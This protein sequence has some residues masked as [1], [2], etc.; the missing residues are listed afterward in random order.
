M[1]ISWLSLFWLFFFYSFIGWCIEVCSAAVQHRKFVNRG[2]VAGPLC[3]IYGFGAMLFEIFLPELTEYPFFLFLGGFVLSSL[4]EYSTGMFFEKVY[5]KKLWDYSRFRYNVGGY[6]CLPFSL[7][8]GALS[9][10]T[11]MFADPLLCGLFDRIPHLLSVILLLVLGGLLLLDTIGSALST[12]SLQL[13]AKHRAD[14]AL[15]KQT[16]RLDQITEGLGQ[17]S[18]FLENALTRHMQKRLQ[19][20]YPSISLDALVKARAERKKSTI[21][22]EGC[23][24][25]KLFS[26]FFIGAFLGD[27]TETI[28]CRITAGVWMSRSSVIYGPFSIVW[29]LG[30]AFLTL[31]LY[32]YRNKSDGSIFLAGTL[33]GGA[34]EYFCSVFTELVFGKVFWDYSKIPFNLGGRINLLYC[35]FWGIAAVVWFKILF[36][37]VEKWIEKIPAVAGKIL[38]W[39]L[40]G[41]MVCNILVSCVAL[42]RYDERGNGV[43]A[44]NAVQ[45]WADAHYD[46]AK[47]KKIYPNAKGIN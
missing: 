26:L 33:L 46:D 29:G 7:L 41:F 23:C 38:T 1:T 12:I 2:F 35:F 14:Y 15:E 24:F 17:T 18:R 22:A 9:V 39:V 11:V 34:Y 6:I 20:S 13:Q 4:L 31:L 40:L 43:Q 8:W 42:V 21:F 5:K 27:I 37:P 32:R 36:P 30:C 19:K 10:V 47:M 44:T 16:A 3:P 28:F 25:Y 45:K